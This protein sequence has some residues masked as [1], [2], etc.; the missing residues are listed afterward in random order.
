MNSLKL[1]TRVFAG[2]NMPHP[3]PLRV[4]G[5]IFDWAAMSALLQTQLQARTAEPLRAAGWGS[6]PGICQA[7]QN[8][9]C[10]H[11]GRSLLEEMSCRLPIYIYISVDNLESPLL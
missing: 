9:G 2:T 7:N 6:L 5:L 8:F 1:K 11:G 3:L 4:P 10:N